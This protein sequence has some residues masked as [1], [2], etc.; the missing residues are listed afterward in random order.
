MLAKQGDTLADMSSMISARLQARLHRI[1]VLK[2]RTSRCLSSSAKY[3]Y[4]NL[5][6]IIPA[7]AP[8]LIETLRQKLS[9]ALRGFAV[10]KHKLVCSRARLLQNDNTGV[11]F[12]ELLIVVVEECPRAHSASSNFRDCVAV[13]SVFIGI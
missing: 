10:S 11:A 12:S 13:F 6:K 5:D 9:S 7:S 1:E 3:H 8:F 4:K 2:T